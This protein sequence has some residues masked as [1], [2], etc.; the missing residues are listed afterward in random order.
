MISGRETGQMMPSTHHS[1]YPSLSMWHNSAFPQV[2]STASP[3]SNY[4]LEATNYKLEASNTSQLSSTMFQPSLTP[5]STGTASPPASRNYQEETASSA[6]VGVASNASSLSP[7]HHAHYGYPPTPP[8]EV[9]AEENSYLFSSSALSGSALN[10]MENYMTA[11]HAKRPE[12][13]SD[14]Y[15]LPSPTSTATPTTTPTSGSSAY[16]MAPFGHSGTFC[17]FSGIKK[18]SASKSKNSNAAAAGTF[19]F[20]FYF[21][22]KPKYL[23]KV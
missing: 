17:N 20:L 9:K 23:K 8:K 18:Q 3:A 12:Q 19:I 6:H 11:S 22:Y 16:E 14:T 21:V 4:K 5:T 10:P 2:P 13:G 15:S 7:D 1:F